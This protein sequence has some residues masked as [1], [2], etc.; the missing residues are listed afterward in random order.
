M[1]G[2]VVFVNAIMS[3]GWPGTAAVMSFEAGS[4]W[5]MAV[6]RRG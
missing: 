6:S 4:F 2:I 3:L 1:S 5:R